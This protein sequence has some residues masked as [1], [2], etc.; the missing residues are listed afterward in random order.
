MDFG[1]GDLVCCSMVLNHLLLGDQVTYIKLGLGL[2][3]ALS[4][5]TGAD[6]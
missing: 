1:K 2:L 5:T 4:R 3:L 6:R